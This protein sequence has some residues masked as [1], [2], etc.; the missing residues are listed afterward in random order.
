MR[1]V[2]EIGQRI[3]MCQIPDFVL[4]GAP[5]GDVLEGRNEAAIRHR[6][7]RNRNATAVGQ[8]LYYRPALAF[9][10]KTLLLSKCGVRVDVDGAAGDGGQFHQLRR[11]HAWQNF[12]RRQAIYLCKATIENDQLAVGVEHAQAL[13]HIG[14]RGVETPVLSRQA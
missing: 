14:Q 6:P 4:G 10:N 2:R 11:R 1:A 7:V 9:A 13:R 12:I 8:A 5:F 3:V